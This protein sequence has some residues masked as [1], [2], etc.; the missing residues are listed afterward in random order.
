ML[1]DDDVTRFMSPPPGTIVGFERF[2]E[3]AR[4]EQAAGRHIGF[5]ITPAGQTDTAIG[6]IQL[7][8][9]TPDFENA[10]WGFAIGSP[11]WGNGIFIDAAH[12]AMTFAFETLGVHRLE[13]RAAVLNGRGNGALAKL[14][15]V[16]ECVLRNSFLRNGKYLDQALWSI[17]REDWQRS[18]AVWGS[19]LH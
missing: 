4:D 15:A 12:L 10:E 1:V 13:A 18:K 16:R 5:A 6:V 8:Q 17:V 3:W 7:R 9:L 11:Y 2:I 14:G 19:S